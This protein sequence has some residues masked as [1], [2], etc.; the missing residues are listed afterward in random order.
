MRA[1]AVTPDDGRDL[2]PWLHALHP[3]TDV[4]LRESAGDVSLWLDACNHAGIRPWLHWRHPR[5]R[6]RP[7]CGVHLPSG[8]PPTSLP[9]GRSCH[10][11]ES[12]DRA[13]AE[14]AHYALLSPVFR[15]TSKPADTRPVLGV[16]QF[17]AL[18]AGRPVVALGGITPART[19]RLQFAGAYGVAVLGAVFGTDPTAPPPHPVWPADSAIDHDDSADRR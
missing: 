16:N 10:D 8:A 9:H 3:F 15:P 17:L 6:D 14:G 7:P 19:R 12:L 18:A 11:A 1:F 4:I 13:F 2:V 5:A